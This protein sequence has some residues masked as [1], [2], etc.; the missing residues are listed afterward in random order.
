M[1]LTKRSELRRLPVRGSHDW[2]TISRVLDASFLANVGFCVDGQ[3][4]VIPT[5]YGRDEERLYLHGLSASRYKQ[6]KAPVGSRG[7]TS[8]KVSTRAL[9]ADDDTYA[10]LE[11][12]LS[13]ITQ[14]R[15]ALAVQ[16]IQLLEG[17]EF[18]GQSIDFKTRASLVSQ[19]NKLL[20]QV[21]HLQHGD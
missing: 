18:N 15:D 5:L 16:S 1:N 19:A 7:L 17:A 10:N 14:Q 6:I 3:P 21:K 2:E 4:F 11:N 20:E 8:L 13:A 12:Q 9:A